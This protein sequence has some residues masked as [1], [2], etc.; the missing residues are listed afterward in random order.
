MSHTTTSQTT[1]LGAGFFFIKMKDATF[2]LCI[3]FKGANQYDLRTPTLS[4]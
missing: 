1:N 4:H 2:Q 3:D